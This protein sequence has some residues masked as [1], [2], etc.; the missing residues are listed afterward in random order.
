MICFVFESGEPEDAVEK[1]VIAFVYVLL[2]V[3]WRTNKG[4]WVLKQW[5]FS[6]FKLI[7]GSIDV[8]GNSSVL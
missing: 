5:S 7:L 1:V 2:K 8:F 4:G 3:G 6:L